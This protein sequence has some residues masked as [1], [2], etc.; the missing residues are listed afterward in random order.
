MARDELQRPISVYGRCRG[1]QF[2]A[3]GEAAEHLHVRPQPC[4]H[5]CRPAPHRAGLLHRHQRRGDREHAVGSAAS[6]DGGRDRPGR[7]RHRAGAGDRAGDRR[8]RPAASDAAAGSVPGSDRDGLRPGRLGFRRGACGPDS[9]AAR[10]RL[11][12][13][14]RARDRDRRR[15][16]ARPLDRRAARPRDRS[17]V[18][19][20]AIRVCALHGRIGRRRHGLHRGAFPRGR[21]STG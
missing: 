3:C 10:R 8:R 14:G 6:D 20:D 2:Y 9:P 11:R 7:R 5:V 18:R 17:R 16:P 1:A 4:D 21:R 12:I 15:R 19:R 13:G